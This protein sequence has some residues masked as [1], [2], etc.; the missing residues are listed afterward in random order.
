MTCPAHQEAPLLV[1]E[2]WI[3]TWHGTPIVPPRSV[4]TGTTKPSPTGVSGHRRLYRHQSFPCCGVWSIWRTAAELTRHDPLRSTWKNGA[5]DVVAGQSSS[6]TAWRGHRPLSPSA[7]MER[8]GTAHPINA[9]AKWSVCARVSRR[10]PQVAQQ[11]KAV[12][13][14]PTAVPPRLHQAAASSRGM[15][16]AW[17][18]SASTLGPDAQP[19]KRRTA[20]SRSVF[21]HTFASDP[22]TRSTRCGGAA[23]SCCS[24][25]RRYGTSQSS[26]G[27]TGRGPAGRKH[28]AGRTTRQNASIRRRRWER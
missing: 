14:E 21:R 16:T 7:T 2:P 27:K 9:A 15:A 3:P 6:C 26:R 25:V 13:T 5:R 1:E 18:S 28:A 19:C 22:K 24:K 20:R 8:P 10:I 23:S 4:W 17:K 12:L 11:V